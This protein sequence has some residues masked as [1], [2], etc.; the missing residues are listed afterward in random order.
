MLK[1]KLDSEPPDNLKGAYV[2]KDGAWFLDDLSDEHPLVMTNKSLNTEQGKL[3]TQID[4]LQATHGNL[5]RERDEYKTKAIPHGYRAVSKEIAELGEMVKQNGLT[6]DEIPNLKSDLDSFRNKEAQ[7]AKVAVYRKAA[8]FLGYT[9]EDAFARLANE[10]E[11][12]ETDGKFTVRVGDEQKELTKEFIE[13]T[14]TFKPFISSLTAQPPKPGN[15]G[16]PKPT[17]AANGFFDRIR[18]AVK[19]ESVQ[20]KADIDA[21]FGKSAPI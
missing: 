12:A 3:K 20:P 18:E 17:G 19:S 2:Q 1:P 21:R 9:N 13:S 5:E 6:K 10:L 16:D 14:D 8:Q 7:A 11:I 4:S 15:G